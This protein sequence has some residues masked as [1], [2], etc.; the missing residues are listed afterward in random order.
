MADRDTL[1]RILDLSRWAPSGDNTQPWRFEI[2]SDAH[3][4]V[5]AFDTRD[6]VLYDLDGRASQLS[7]GMLLETMRVAASGEGLGMEYARRPGSPDTHPIIDVYLSAE[8]PVQRDP[9]FPCLKVRATQRRATRRRPLTDTEK[10]MLEQSLGEGC[11]VVWLE[12]A[13]KRKASWLL[14]RLA[15]V[16]LRM[17]EAFAVHSQI[18]EWNARYSEDKL[19]AQSIGL[20]PLMTRMLPLFMGDW[21]RFRFMNRWLL[22]TLLPS[23]EL[24]LVPALFS[25][26]H[27][28]LFS[29]QLPGNIDEQLKAGQAIQRFWLTA[30]HLGLQLQPTY[31]AVC[32]AK[33]HSEGKHVSTEPGLDERLVPILR[34]FSH[35]YGQNAWERAFF[36]GRVGAGA[37]P[38]SRSVRRPL[39]DLFVRDA[40]P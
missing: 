23:I 10:S 33:Y 27:F 18:V 13:R 9:L 36:M 32:F 35:L 21:K 2:V 4:A 14:F 37:A 5:H 20:N 6:E 15:D 16:R 25:G 24:D 11:R 8:P 26:A 30:A 40:G 1:L 38:D 3:V 22:G 34:D 17:P 7:V 28:L 29:E 39:R 19:P 12:G 31:S